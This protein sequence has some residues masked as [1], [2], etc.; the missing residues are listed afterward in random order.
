MAIFLIFLNFFVQKMYCLNCPILSKL[1]NFVQIFKSLARLNQIFQSCFG[2]EFGN[3]FPSILKLKFNPNSSKIESLNNF[4]W[5]INCTA[6]CMNSK[7]PYFLSLVSQLKR[8]FF[9]PKMNGYVCKSYQRKTWRR[10]RVFCLIS[11][12]TPQKMR[13]LFFF[14]RHTHLV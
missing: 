9:A 1:S 5:T 4:D 6:K 14:L 3:N 10:R 8:Q 13:F 11:M 2:S 7:S 12:S